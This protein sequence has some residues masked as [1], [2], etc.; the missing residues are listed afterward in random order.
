VAIDEAADAEATG[1]GSTELATD[2]PEASGRGVRSTASDEPD[3]RSSEPQASEIVS[4]PG[5]EE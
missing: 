1:E 5:E 4:E 3:S 2:T